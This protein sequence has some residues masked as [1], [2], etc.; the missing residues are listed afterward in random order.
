MD[1]RHYPA[2][3][4]TSRSSPCA[5]GWKTGWCATSWPS[6]SGCTTA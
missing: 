4:P 6:I 5:R 3:C 2:A 1:E